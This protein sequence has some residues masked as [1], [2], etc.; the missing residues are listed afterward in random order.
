MAC[1]EGPQNNIGLPSST[2]PV[3]Q[4]LHLYFPYL[5]GHSTPSAVNVSAL[6]SVD[7]TSFLLLTL[8]PSSS[9]TTSVSYL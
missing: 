2:C 8:L 1:G 3:Y 5:M 4:V 9:R 7:L 6:F